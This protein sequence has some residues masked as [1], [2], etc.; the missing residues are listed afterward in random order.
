[1]PRSAAILAASSGSGPVV[2]WPSVSMMIAAEL[3]E[4]GATG[5]KSSFF[6]SLSPSMRGMLRWPV[7]LWI[8]IPASGKSVA[9]DSMMPLPVAVPRWS[10][11]RSDGGD[12]VVFAEGRRLHD[13]RRA[14]ERDHAHAHFVRQV[15]DEALA[16]SCEATRR[17][18]FTS[19]ARMLPETSIARM[20]VRSAIAA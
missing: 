7:M 17:F 13:C 18:G 19:S 15:V 10:W 11:K 1:M 12:R 4:P 6:G 3:Y 14:G 2:R 8:S 16:A 20:I 5:L 9:S